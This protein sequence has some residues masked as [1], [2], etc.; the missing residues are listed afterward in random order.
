MQ[1]LHFMGDEEYTY[2][3]EPWVMY[4]IVGSLYCTP[5]AHITLNVNYTG[6]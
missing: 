4:K 5:E 3:D 2:Y 1:M 6:I